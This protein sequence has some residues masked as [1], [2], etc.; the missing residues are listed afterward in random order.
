MLWVFLVYPYQYTTFFTNFPRLFGKLERFG[1]VGFQFFWFS[2]LLKNSDKKVGEVGFGKVRQGSP[3]FPKV[4]QG[5]PRFP[6]VPQG[7]PRFPKV[8]QGSARFGKVR[9]GSARFGKVRQG[10]V[11][12]GFG[13]AW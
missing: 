8:R 5:S 7:S 6:K 9:Q 11:W 4:P 3:R 10:S 13:L 2:D 1:W 12:F